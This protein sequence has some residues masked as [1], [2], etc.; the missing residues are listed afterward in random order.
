[1][2][3]YYGHNIFIVFLFIWGAFSSYVYNT[4][5]WSGIF[6]R[7]PCN[8]I[9]QR[10]QYEYVNVPENQQWWIVSELI[11]FKANDSKCVYRE[12]HSIAKTAATMHALPSCFEIGHMHSRMLPQCVSIRWCMT[13]NCAR[14]RSINMHSDHM[15]S[16]R[17]LM[18][19]PGK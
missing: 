2:I 3:D 11:P 13:T 9:D 15:P 10:N 18:L 7:N 16:Q 12:A 17:F 4:M 6:C 5:N 1:M 14:L 8:D 19:C